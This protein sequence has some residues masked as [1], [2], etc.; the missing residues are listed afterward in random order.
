MNG[1][2]I[3]RSEFVQ[4]LAEGRVTLQW[5][6]AKPF[7]PRTILPCASTTTAPG[8]REESLFWITGQGREERFHNRYKSMEAWRSKC[9]VYRKLPR[10]QFA[11]MCCEFWRLYQGKVLFSWKVSTEHYFRSSHI[12]QGC[13]DT[14]MRSYSYEVALK[15]RKALCTTKKHEIE[16]KVQLWKGKGKLFIP[17]WC[18]H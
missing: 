15:T 11:D 7:L 2:D 9:A 6:Q 5:S 4:L 16:V 14:Q 1:G 17:A 10:V 12:S 18:E 13:C 8:K 3:Y